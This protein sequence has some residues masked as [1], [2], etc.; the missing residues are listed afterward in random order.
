MDERALRR[1]IIA[2]ALAMSARGLNRGKSGNVSARIESGFLVTPTGLAYETMR[3]EDIVAMNL[4]GKAGGTRTPSSEWRF[5][6]DIYG[7]RAEVAAIVH[8]HSPFATTLACLGR[9]IPAF[10]YM[11]AVGGGKDIR[12]A[13]YAT[14]GTQELSERALRALEDRKACLLANHGM[15]AMGPTLV[16]AL[17]LAVE[18]EAL[19]EQYWRALQIGEPNLLPDA[20]MTRVLEKFKTY[21]QPR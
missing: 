12:C 6:R 4:Q 20:E 9:G 5:H 19:A 17:A 11:I 2:T 3:P 1:E 8:A 10:H 21:G 7:A 13:P 15:I 18:V 16:D 14:F